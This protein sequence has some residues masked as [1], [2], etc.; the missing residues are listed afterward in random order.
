VI[1]VEIV[2]YNFGKREHQG[3]LLEPT[4]ITNE[5]YHLRS[6]FLKKC[7]AAAYK[8]FRDTFL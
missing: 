3:T 1:A 6:D 5:I 8:T 7:G 4:N 2:Y